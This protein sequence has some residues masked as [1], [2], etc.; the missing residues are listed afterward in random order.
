MERRLASMKSGVLNWASMDL[1]S[2]WCDGL[3]RHDLDERIEEIESINL[4]NQYARWHVPRL[5]SM[6]QQRPEGV[7]RLT[8][9]QLNSASSSEV[10][11]RNTEDIIRLIK[12]WE[13]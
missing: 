10:R 3:K 5:G 2:K 1:V 8:G 7:F 11:S 13:I 4:A 6:S 9:G 12:D